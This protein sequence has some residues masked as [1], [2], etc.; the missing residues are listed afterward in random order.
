MNAW[1]LWRKILAVFSAFYTMELTS[2]GRKCS[3]TRYSYVCAHNAITAAMRLSW[4]C[5]INQGKTWGPGNFVL[6]SANNELAGT[7]M[8][9]ASRIKR[10]FHLLWT[11]DRFTS[12]DGCQRKP[13]VLIYIY[14]MQKVC[15]NVCVLSLYN[16]LSFSVTWLNFKRLD[17]LNRS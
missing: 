6:G 5:I 8:W 9:F 7:L 13:K 4:K 14:S 12:Q 1:L 16:F 10:R 17:S 11:V 3:L 15:F 2:S